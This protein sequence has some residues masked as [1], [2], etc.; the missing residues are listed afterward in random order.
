M[1]RY[2]CL[3]AAA[4]LSACAE[5]P[6]PAPHVDGET[7]ERAVQHAQAQANTGPTSE[8]VSVAVLANELGR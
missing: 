6:P 3:A 5:A 4:C 7:I 2:A 8:S 1:I